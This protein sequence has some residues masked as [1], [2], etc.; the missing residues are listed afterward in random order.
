MRIHGLLAAVFPLLVACSSGT[1]ASSGPG[2]GDGLAGLGGAAGASGDGASG[3]GG[4]TAAPLPDCF[5]EPRNAAGRCEAT[6]LADGLASPGDFAF[7]VAAARGTAFVAT[8]AGLVRVSAPNE[9][10]TLDDVAYRVVVAGDYV[11]WTGAGNQIKVADLSNPGASR[12]LSDFGADELGT[13]G[14]YLLARK[15]ATSEL[16]RIDPSAEL[17]TA[18]LV[19]AVPRVADG[20]ATH[21]YYF[22]ASYVH[23]SDVSRVPIDGGTPQLLASLSGDD[24]AYGAYLAVSTSTVFFTTPAGLRSVSKTTRGAPSLLAAGKVP[25]LVADSDRSAVFWATTAGTIGRI[26]RADADGKSSR[27]LA[28]LPMRSVKLAVDETA[29]YILDFVEGSLYRLPKR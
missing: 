6:L 23:G 5:G 25:A 15:S 24:E 16:L 27:L 13:N 22:S 11:A 3:E 1:E 4:S 12:V 10:T 20:D 26:Y 9:K 8:T 7:A 2:G 19:A 29:L 14:T 17:P 21:A 28:E 18:R